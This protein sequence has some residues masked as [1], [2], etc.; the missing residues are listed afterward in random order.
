MTLQI[1]EDVDY[2][3][4]LNTNRYNKEVMIDTP[5]AKDVKVTMCDQTASGYPLKC[6]E[7][8]VEKVVYPVYSNT[9]SNNYFGRLMTSHIDRAKMS[10]AKATNLHCENDKI[11]FTGSGSSGAITH[12]V[13]MIKP[14]FNNCTVFVSMIEHYSNYLPWFHVVNGDEDASCKA[15]E[16]KFMHID[17][18]TG[19]IDM[20]RFV[21]DL[22]ESVKRKRKIIVSVTACSNVSGVLQDIYA[23]ARLCHAA[24]GLCF[25]DFAAAAPY[26]AINM[27]KNDSTGEYLDGIFISPHKFPGAQ[28]SP[29]LLLVSKRIVCNNTTYTPSGGTV[30]FACSSNGPIYSN[31]LE[32]KEMG[33]TPNIVGIVKTGLAFDVKTRF[34]EE[35][36]AHEKRLTEMFQD[37]LLDVQKANSNLRILNPVNNTTRLPIFA[38]QIAPFHYN[39]IVVLLNDLF[40]IVTR[41][42]ISCS[43][44]FAEETLK[45][46]PV[47]LQ[48]VQAS[49]LSG[50]G[51]PADYGWVRITLTSVHTDDDVRYVANAVDHLCRHA[52]E[53]KGA[54][55]YAKDKNVYFSNKCED[56]VCSTAHVNG[57]RV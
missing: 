2:V 49:I 8:Y 41:G 35:I 29:G 46:S 17:D 3:S 39:Y 50:N 53:Y 1:P 54:Y 30:R 56:G 5:L 48:N 23:I 51:V 24:S 38:L 10:V 18:D 45:L 20:R 44:L 11:I 12:L 52:A 34:F 40:G 26:V 33:G 21:V 55:R 27:H 42:G 57:R 15:N 4:F 13:H 32:I 6:I 9:H 7:D 43:A 16:L 22:K 14:M 36:V 31:N 37:M 25:V 28:S 47:E 19:K